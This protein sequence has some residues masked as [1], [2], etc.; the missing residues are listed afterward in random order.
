MTSDRKD[1]TWT[2]IVE[3]RPAGLAYHL[4]PAEYP[5]RHPDAPMA[6]NKHV[7]LLMQDVTAWNAWRVENPDILPDLR[8]ADLY[9]AKLAGANLRRAKLTKLPV[10]FA[11]WLGRTFSG[12]LPI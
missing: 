8:W 1:R 4:H 5:Y 10:R 6:N 12:T 9:A 2:G 3:R 7:A 11:C